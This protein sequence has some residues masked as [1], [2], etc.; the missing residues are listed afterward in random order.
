MTVLMRF[1]LTSG[2][3]K[4]AGQV[5]IATCRTEQAYIKICENQQSSRPPLQLKIVL[6]SLPGVI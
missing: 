2:V 6:A 1:S 5:T 4:T 3:T